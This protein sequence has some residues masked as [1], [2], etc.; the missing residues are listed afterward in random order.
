ME[1]ELR[2]SLPSEFTNFVYEIESNTSLLIH[3]LLDEDPGKEKLK[4]L[5]TIACECIDNNIP[6]GEFLS[7]WVAVI[8]VGAKRVH[9]LAIGGSQIDGFEGKT[10]NGVSVN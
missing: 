4:L 3:F 10:K 5:K 8:R 1:R 9:N 6:V 7:T 2:N